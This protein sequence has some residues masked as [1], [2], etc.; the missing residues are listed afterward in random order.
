MHV[1]RTLLSAMSCD[2]VLI[3]VATVINMEARKVDL[4]VKP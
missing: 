3:F 1:A 4:N 2:T